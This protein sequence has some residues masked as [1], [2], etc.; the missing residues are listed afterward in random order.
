MVG[1]AP[2]RLGHVIGEVRV[3]RELGR[4]AAEEHGP[5]RRPHQPS[6]ARLFERLE[7]ALPVG[8]RLR[9]EHV[10]VAG[11]D[12]GHAGRGQRITAGPG[13]AV[14]LHDHGDV[15]GPDRPDLGAV[16]VRR[17]GGEQGLHVR[18]EVGRDERPQ[19]VHRDAAGAA[20]PERVAGDHPQ[21]ER[22]VAGGPGQ[23]LSL[24][25]RRD[26]AHHDVLVA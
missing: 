7:K 9:G 19:V 5:G 21:P 1:P 26:L 12:G 3:G 4:G 24:A 13:V 18:R 6:P 25:P 11:V 15:T 10:G 2:H 14:A 20:D 17:V 22:V 23:S 16:V 8:R